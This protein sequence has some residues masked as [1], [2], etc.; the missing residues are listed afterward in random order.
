MP[1]QQI[2]QALQ[3]LALTQER[4]RIRREREAAARRARKNA[5]IG[6]MGAIAGGV[7]G[8]PAGAAAGQLIAVE[9][10]G[11]DAEISPSQISNLV[12]AGVQQQAQKQQNAELAAL[13]DPQP[14]TSSGPGFDDVSPAPPIDRRAVIAK[15]AEIGQP[16]AAA[17]FALQQPKRRIAT[18]VGG[19]PRFVDTGQRV[20]PGAQPKRTTAQSSN[21]FTQTALTSEFQN[22]DSETVFAHIESNPNRFPGFNRQDVVGD[23]LIKHEARLGKNSTAAFNRIARE[24]GPTATVAT[25]EEQL[26]QQGF[27]PARVSPKIVEAHLKRGATREQKTFLGNV[28]KIAAASTLSVDQKITNIGKQIEKHQAQLTPQQ[29]EHANTLMGKLRGAD[30]RVSESRQ[31]N[32]VRLRRQSHLN[33]ATRKRRQDFIEFAQANPNA[34]TEE[35]AAATQIS[36]KEIRAEYL[37]LLKA[38]LKQNIP[39]AEKRVLREEIKVVEAEQE[40]RSVG[41]KPVGT[42]ENPATPKSKAAFDA[43]PSGAVYID[44]RDPEKL[45]RVKP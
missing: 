34:T 18:D 29:I 23:V 21:A 22:A 25:I 1:G 32:L 15:L 26:A 24:A 17:Q 5:R 9:L 8:G 41:P 16:G 12:L 40:R 39:E 38:N 6:A 36:P 4:G 28:G 14:E 35:F 42:R 30:E 7:V 37:E 3:S 43:L 31:A 11:E 10:L 2:I 13:F 27:E 44:P 19:R 45:P 20:F 33:V